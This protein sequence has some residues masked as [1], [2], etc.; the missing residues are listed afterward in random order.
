VVLDNLCNSNSE[1][2]N[3]VKKLTGKHFDF[4]E[5]DIRNRELLDRIFKCYPVTAVLHFAGLKSVSESVDMPLSYYDN[6]IEGTLVLCKAMA[7]AGINNL[8]FSSS[9]T[10]YGTP[11]SLPIRESMPLSSTTPYGRSKLIVEQILKDM[12]DAP[13]SE[14]SIIALRYF[15]P[16]GAHP[17]GM[18]GEDPKE[19]PN[20]LMP[21]ITQ[22]A[23]GK[24]SILHVFGDN[25][26]TC[27]GTG[28][29]DYIHVVDLAVGH[30]RA[31]E[32]LNRSTSPLGTLPL[33]LGT[34]YGVSVL[35]LVKAFEQ[36][37]GVK[38]PFDVQA[39]RTGDVSACYADASKAQQELN[40]CATKGIREMV[41]DSWNWQQN[42][43][44]GYQVSELRN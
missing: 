26:D 29:R 2:V 1:S 4:I 3:R 28:V 41:K 42:N 27:D 40:W 35:E 5:G 10:V 36:E 43:P 14:W 34:G 24:R 9:A 31:I 23:I 25:Y 13:D 15:N 17:S 32:K 37:N 16:V 19:I 12:A 21:Y 7:N 20:N 18:I 30:V 33:N 11:E 6:N 39:R 22:T 44:E 38:V 8:V